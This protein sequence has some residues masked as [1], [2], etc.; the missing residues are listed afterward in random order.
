MAG[1]MLAVTHSE[2]LRQCSLA[3]CIFNQMIQFLYQ[4]T[5]I[6][7]VESVINFER[8]LKKLMFQDEFGE[9]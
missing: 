4:S 6:L 3:A 7:F 8:K 1:C 9:L 5:C 2:V